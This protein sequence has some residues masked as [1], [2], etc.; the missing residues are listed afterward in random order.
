[1]KD[2]T[3]RK[4]RIGIGAIAFGPPPIVSFDNIIIT[5]PTEG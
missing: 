5:T 3:F 4:G 1:M 2:N